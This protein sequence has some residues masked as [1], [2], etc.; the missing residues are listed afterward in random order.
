MN[1]TLAATL[2]ATAA[3]IGASFFGVAQAIWPTHPA[4]CRLRDHDRVQHRD[5]ANL[6]R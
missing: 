1:S 5:K 3:G 6:A 4:N 2:I